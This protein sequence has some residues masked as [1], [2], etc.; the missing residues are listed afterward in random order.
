MVSSEVVV[1]VGTRGGNLVFVGTGEGEGG[2]E[3]VQIG[4][5]V[6]IGA[7]GVHKLVFS[8]DGQQIFA[9]PVG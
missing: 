2:H 6:W 7:A 3:L 4:E 5:P 8:D 1:V 9:F